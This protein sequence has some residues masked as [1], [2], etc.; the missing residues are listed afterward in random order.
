[1]VRSAKMGK[2]AGIVIIGDEI[3]GG[4]FRD[5]NGPYLIDELRSLGVSLKRIAVIGDDVAEIAETVGGFSRTYDLV[6]TSGGIGPTHDDLTMRG[7]ANAFDREIG[8]HPDLEARLRAHFGEGITPAQLS[9]GTTPV[10]AQL[11]F[12]DAARWPTVCCENVYILPGVPKFLRRQFAEIRELF[13]DTPVRAGRVFVAAEETRVVA[14]LDAV[15]AGFPDVKFGSYPRFDEVTFQLIITIEATTDA[16]ISA[17][18]QAL[19]QQ[20]GALVVSVDEPVAASA[21]GPTAMEPN[22]DQSA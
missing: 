4:T 7:I 16:R 20:L 21:D 17:A 19:C 11:C 15:V 6:F 13:R 10:G 3:L 5:E 1:M 18:C 22:R 9:L 8:I 2:T 12:G 14:E